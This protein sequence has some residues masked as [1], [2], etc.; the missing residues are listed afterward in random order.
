MTRERKANL[1]KKLRIGLYIF[2]ATFT[3]LLIL[4]ALCLPSPEMQEEDE[5][6]ATLPGPVTGQARAEMTHEEIQEL[7][8]EY[9]ALTV[10][11]ENA[12]RTAE[13]DPASFHLTLLTGP[14]QECAKRYREL[15]VEK[16]NTKPEAAFECALSKTM[17]QERRR[18]WQDLSQDE[19]KARA[20]Q[21]MRMLALSMDPPKLMTTNIAARR[22]LRVNSRTNP[23]FATFAANYDTCYA[24]A[25]AFAPHLAEAESAQDMVLVWQTANTHL[26]RCYG[27]IT[28][29]LF[30]PPPK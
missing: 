7:I 2:L 29:N 12:H 10:W 8:I 24:Q 20:L 27:T 22:G 25:Q 15:R 14:D 23:D 3:G 11:A 26:D 4:V 16:P 21:G 17:S 9:L 5:T 28:E 6:N 1:A 13:K 18:D 30:P 19:Q